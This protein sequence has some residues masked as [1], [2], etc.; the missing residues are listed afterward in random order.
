MIRREG[1]AWELL[2]RAIAILARPESWL[3]GSWHAA[4]TS[5]GNS[6]PSSFPGAA[7]WTVN[8]ALTRAAF[9]TKAAYYLRDFACAEVERA[10][11]LEGYRLTEWT[12]DPARTHIE[13]LS[14]LQ[15]AFDREAEAV[16][17]EAETH[18]ENIRSGALKFLDDLAYPEALAHL[19][20]IR[21]TR[22]RVAKIVEAA[23]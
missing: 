15:K 6:C 13:V 18:L 5:R 22:E 2:A 19:E 17:K 3:H 10:Q 11:G 1:L 12:N 16:Q 21:Q 9:D 23:R 7:K 4:V 14:A 20:R 8:G